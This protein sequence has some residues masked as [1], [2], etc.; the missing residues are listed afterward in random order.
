[1]HGIDLKNQMDIFYNAMNYTSKGIIDVSCYGGFKRISGEK[2][3]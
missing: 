3:R 1:M 2:V